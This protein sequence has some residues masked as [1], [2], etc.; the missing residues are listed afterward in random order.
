MSLG[1]QP[2]KE[3]PCRAGVGTQPSEMGLLEAGEWVRG[4]I[5]LDL[6]WRQQCHPGH[7]PRIRVPGMPGDR[8]WREAT[9]V[10]AEV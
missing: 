10:L 4:L 9:S 1:D 8:R 6:V 7:G 5:R 3:V 2:K